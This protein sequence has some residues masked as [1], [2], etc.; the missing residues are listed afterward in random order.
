[1]KFLNK[2]LILSPSTY[3]LCV[4]RAC[5]MAEGNTDYK[6]MTNRV[7]TWAKKNINDSMNLTEKLTF[8]S[9]AN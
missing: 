3:T 7:D 4:A 6:N 2:W 1:M 5:L 9:G 8:I